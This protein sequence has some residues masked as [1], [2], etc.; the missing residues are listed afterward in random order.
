MKTNTKVTIKQVTL[1]KPSHVCSA[2][3][4]ESKLDFLRR[5]YR[6]AQL[7]ARLTANPVRLQRVLQS[8]C[9]KAAWHV[10]NVAAWN[11][12]TVQ[13]GDSLNAAM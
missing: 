10:G 3:Q 12:E 7:D 2:S 5:Q 1:H 13:F 9:N 8:I 4:S 6:Q 11:R